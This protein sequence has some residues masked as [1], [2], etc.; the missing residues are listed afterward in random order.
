MAAP[1]NT[2]RPAITGTTQ[3]G[4][5][6]TVSS[7]TW[8]QP[9]LSYTYQW[10]LN[11]ASIAGA[12]KS[13]YTIDGSALGQ[14]ISARVN[15]T[16]ASYADASATTLATAVVSV[17]PRALSTAPPALSGAAQVGQVMKVTT[18]TWNTTGLTFAYAWYR[19]GVVISG[20]TGSTHSVVAADRGHRITAQ[21]TASRLG[22][23]TATAKTAASATVLDAP[24]AKGT[25]KAS[26][27][28]TSTVQ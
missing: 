16:S 10:Y 18:G 3:V 23:N 22:Y 19:D 11:G 14:K 27:T 13:T 6:L 24:P 2:V 9:G 20:A 4:S 12:T 26:P 15:A 5:T 7:G 21:V 8:S 17:G 1:V 28:A 25:A